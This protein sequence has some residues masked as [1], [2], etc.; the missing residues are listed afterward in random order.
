MSGLKTIRNRIS[1][2]KSTRKITS[3]MKMVSA[4]RLR[5]LQDRLIALRPYSDKLHEVVLGLTGLPG[6]AACENVYCRQSS[7][8][9]ILLIL[10]TSNRGLCGAF[11]Q[12]LFREVKRVVS[13]LYA[14]QLERG[15]LSFIAVGKKGYEFL[16]R[17]YGNCRIEQYNHISESVDFQDVSQLGTAIMAGFREELYD[18]VHLVCNSFKN[19]A[20]QLI[21]SETFLP[22]SLEPVDEEAPVITDYIYEPDRDKLIE[23][24]IPRSIKLR[25]YRA[26]LDAGTAEHGARMT[27]MHKATDNAG[28]LIESL[29]LEYNKLRQSAVTAQIL[30]VAGGAEALK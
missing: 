6:S 3:A 15:S 24:I 30:E 4:A 21:V 26:L 22:V 11:N 20:S 28:E 7:P 18:R 1:T 9:K 10:S 12:Q 16:R 27:A 8:D 13:E 5:R 2:V 25:L 19:A 14:E 17:Q 23:A 29:T